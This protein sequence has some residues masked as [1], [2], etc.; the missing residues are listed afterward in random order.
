MI[1]IHTISPFQGLGFVALP[2]HSEGRYYLAD[3][4]RPFRAMYCSPERASSANEG[5][6]PSDKNKNKKSPERA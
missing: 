6:S 1:A 2:S 3:I 5:H 4:C